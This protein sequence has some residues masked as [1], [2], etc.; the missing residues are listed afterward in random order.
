M[1]DNILIVGSTG[2]TGR[3][4]MASLR[5]V[6]AIGTSRSA[7]ARGQVLFDWTDCSTFDDALDGIRAVYMIAPPGDAEPL[8]VMRPFIDRALDLGVDRLVLLSSSMLGEG[9]ALM[10]AVH[11]YLKEAAVGWTVLRPSWFMQ[12]FSEHQHAVTIRDEGRIYS[13]TGDGLVPFI[14][15]ADIAAVAAEALVD[16]DFPNGD[17]IL[18]GPELLT[19]DAVARAISIAAGRQIIHCRQSIEQMTERFVATGIPQQFA[20]ALSQMDGAIASGAENR[21]TGEVARVTGREPET[22]SRFA[23]DNA[24]TWPATLVGA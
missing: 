3:S 6:H 10:G 12:N 17:L 13:A 18:T 15:V 11:G 21:L 23:R 14:D 5:G 2:K 7:G 22:F 8:L 24:R 16:R 19:Y 20:E 1:P 9:D 4:L